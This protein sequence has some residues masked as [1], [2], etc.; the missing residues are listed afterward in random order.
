MPQAENGKDKDD[1][2]RKFISK[3]EAWPEDDPPTPADLRALRREIRLT[4]SD[5]DKL[6]LLAENHI[7][8]ARTSLDAGAYDQAAAELARAAQ[9]RPLDAK[10]RVEL[11]EIYLQRSLERGYRRRDRGKAVKLAQKALELSP[12]DPDARRFIREYRRMNAD[13][14]SIKVRRFVGPVVLTLLFAAAIGWWQRDWVIGLVRPAEFQGALSAANI[15]DTAPPRVRDVELDTGG[16][17]DSEVTAEVLSASVGR[18]NDGSFLDIRAKFRTETKSVGKMELLV[19]GRDDQGNQV[20]TLPWTARNDS[21]PVLLPGDTDAV[22]LYRWLAESEEEV[23]SLELL[24]M[25]IESMNIQELPET[26]DVEIVWDSVRPDGSALSAAARNFKIIE[27]YDAQILFMDLAL[28]NSGNTDISSLSFDVSISQ[29]ASSSASIDLNP[30]TPPMSRGERRVWPIVMTLP[31]D[32]NIPGQPLV[33][34]VLE[35]Q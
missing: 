5:R 13:F 33:M 20:F 11:A 23:K 8:R 32:A 17:T 14:R 3:L 26:S 7:R 29:N 34:K 35:A 27:A 25:N 1:S 6:E 31:L 21:D 30:E 12:Q 4:E 15:P 18:R 22:A 19:R 24:P 16:L 28:E 10:P 9:L 2:L